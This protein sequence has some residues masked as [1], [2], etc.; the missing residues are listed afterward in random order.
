MCVATDERGAPDRNRTIRLASARD[1]DPL[2]RTIP[3][4]PSPDGVAN[5]QIVS[6]SPPRIVNPNVYFAGSTTNGLFAKTR[7]V[8]IC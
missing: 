3:I 2:R 4:P 7:S 8:T 1:C 5:A 6:S